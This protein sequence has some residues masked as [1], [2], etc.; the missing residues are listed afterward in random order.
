LRVLNAIQKRMPLL[1]PLGTLGVENVDEALALPVLKDH[2]DGEENTEDDEDPE[3][4]NSD[5]HWA[6]PTV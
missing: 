5:D 3:G 4:G 1:R 6:S 2:L